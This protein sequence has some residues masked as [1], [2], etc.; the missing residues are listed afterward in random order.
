MVNVVGLYLVRNEVDLIEA[1]LLHHFATAIDEAIVIDN[2]ST[3]GTLEEVGRLSR[4]LPIHLASEP[5]AYDQAARVTRMA[6]WASRRGADWLLPIDADEFWIGIDAPLRS[7]LSELPSHVTALRAEVTNFVQERDV[8]VADAT[9]LLSMTMRPE[10]QIGPIER[11]EE[12]V[13]QEHIAFVEMM[14]PPK[15]VSRASDTVVIGPGN[16]A[17]SMAS[18]GVSLDDRAHC[19]HAPLRAR[20]LL[21]GKLDQGRRVI[22]EDPERGD[23]WHVRRWWRRSRDGMMGAEWAANSH[24]GGAITVG[25]KVKPLVE[26]LRLREAVA[27]FV[28]DAP[29]ERGSTVRDAMEPSIGAYLLALDSVPGWFSALDARLLVAFD[30]LQRGHSV[31]G[32]LFEIGVFCGKSAILLGH[33]A[34]G[35]GDHLVVCDLFEDTAAADENLAEFEHWYPGFRQQDFVEQYLRFHSELPTIMV[36]AST[37]ID[38]VSRAGT[39]R[40]VHVDGSHTYD[41]VR[42]D[43]RTAETLL[44][45][46]GIVAFDD[47][48]TAHNP[49]SALAV[50]E[51]VLSG[52]FVPLC[53]TPA[54]LYGSWDP[55]VAQW[56]AELD[57]WISVTDAVECEIHT[58]AGWPVRRLSSVPRAAVPQEVLRTV[59]SLEDLEDLEVTDGGPSP[60]V[61]NPVCRSNRAPGAG[62]RVRSPTTW[63]L[64]WRSPR[65]G[66]SERVVRAPLRSIDAAAPEGAARSASTAGRIRPAPASTLSGAARDGGDVRRA[67]SASGST[68]RSGWNA[69]SSARPPRPRRLPRPGRPARRARF[70]S[71]PRR[72]AP[73]RRPRTPGRHRARRRRAAPELGRGAHRLGALRTGHRQ[74]DPGLAKL[75]LE[76][77]EPGQGAPEPDIA[78]VADGGEDELVGLG[79]RVLE[80]LGHDGRVRVW[81]RGTASS[82]VNRGS[83][84]RRVATAT[85]PACSSSSS[86]VR[87][88][89]KWRWVRSRSPVGR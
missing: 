10:H 49:G 59:P 38:A 61:R 45:P 57:E 83:T 13:E 42:R 87:W 12:L 15:W 68:G 40:L 31:E 21:V 62:R 44:G 85:N 71:A 65:T 58:L 69:T 54:K 70:A 64:R 9:S 2:G 27:A 74:P 32:D 78:G 75:L 72:P 63:R 81:W 37:E 53:L 51:E 34:R 7:V 18:E 19:L 16:H 30:R 24:E 35:S 11:C 43:I 73:T 50:W 39:C 17:T 8:R 77:G 46:G 26:D 55:Q 47:I 25:G 5:G 60:S 48:S 80:D 28:P 4:T 29:M 89:K 82:V 67:A 23:Y 88:V 41:I 3:D 79:I 6:R 52:R 33:L 36:G 86:A 76:A 14:Y 22:E 84:I 66:G 56:L 1:N 20:S